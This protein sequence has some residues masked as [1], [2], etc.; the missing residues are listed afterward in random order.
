M[1]IKTAIKTL[2]Q[3][4]AKLSARKESYRPR[5]RVAEIQQNDDHH[6]VTIQV[7]NKNI[8]Y[9]AKPE[10]ILS[11]DKFV[12]CFSPKDIRTL[13]YLG[14]LGINTPKYKILAKRLSKENDKFTFALKERGNKKI[15]TKTAFEISNEKSILKSL[16][17]QDAHLL[18]YTLASESFIDERKQKE[19]AIKALFDNN[20]YSLD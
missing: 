4:L 14:Y 2:K 9:K 18:G 10:D 6:M 8:L 11:K 20:H 5:Y 15:I 7:I 13:T 16:P 17:V 3:Q 19:I 12:D 1:G